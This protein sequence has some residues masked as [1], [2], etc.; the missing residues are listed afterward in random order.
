MSKQSTNTIFTGNPLMGNSNFTN[1]PFARSVAE[2]HPELWARY[3]AV[4]QRQRALT[5]LELH[6]ARFDNFY[7][8]SH[9]AA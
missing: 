6:R 1:R 8:S 5:F 3:I 9:R 4:C 7:A 2:A